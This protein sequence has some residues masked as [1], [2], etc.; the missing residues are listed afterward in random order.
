MD[1]DPKEYT[2]DKNKSITEE[3]RNEI[4]QKIIE[5]KNNT[6]TQ[7]NIKEIDAK[8]YKKM[9]NHN[10]TTQVTTKETTYTSSDMELV[11]N[12]DKFLALIK[13]NSEGK[14]DK[15]GE[16][17]KY[18]KK[19]GKN[20]DEYDIESEFLSSIDMVI[21]ILERD[22]E[23]SSYANTMKYI[24]YRYTNNK[25]YKTDLDFSSYD[26]SDFKD[27]GSD[28]TSGSGFEQFKRWIHTYEGGKKEGKFYIVQP[29]GGRRK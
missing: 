21:D 13:A 6:I 24:Y 2:I 26:T 19:E 18:I 29:D 1:N 8:V 11:D 27:V 7:D 25:A 15:K 9:T 4:I 16:L 5:A 12:T 10:M 3:Q 22:E 23:V 20:D 14:F 17:V 28:A